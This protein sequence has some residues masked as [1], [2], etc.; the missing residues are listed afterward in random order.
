[1]A[2]HLGHRFLG[3]HHFLNDSREPSS[4]SLEPWESIDQIICDVNERSSYQAL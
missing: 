1:M 4:L 3:K 2:C